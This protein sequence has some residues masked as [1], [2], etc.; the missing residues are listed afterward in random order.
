MF[1]EIEV[2]KVGFFF[3]RFRIMGFEVVM[4]LNGIWRFWEYFEF[5]V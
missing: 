1:E 3:R 5:R 2:V 4:R